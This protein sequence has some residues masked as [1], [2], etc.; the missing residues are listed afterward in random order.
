MNV[1]IAMRAMEFRNELVALLNKYNTEISG[2][3]FDD[4]S[5]NIDIQYGENREQFYI[6]DASDIRKSY[7]LY[8]EYLDDIFTGVT[9]DKYKR[10]VSEPI[11]KYLIKQMFP[12]KNNIPIEWKTNKVIHVL[13]MNQNKFKELMH[14]KNPTE[15]RRSVNEWYF[16]SED[17][18]R[19]IMIRPNMNSRGTKIH[20]L[21]IDENL[22]F[23]EC[24]IREIILPMCIYLTRDNIKFF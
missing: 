6:T 24:G 1:E 5:I 11:K 15:V 17:G 3:S 18:F 22:D 12:E 4:G 13:T 16:D 20:N 21:I 10:M 8:H 7:E 14:S 9:D 2:S 23:S 19:Y